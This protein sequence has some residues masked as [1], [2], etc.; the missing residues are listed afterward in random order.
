MSVVA[1]PSALFCVMCSDVSVLTR[2]IGDESD[3]LLYIPAYLSE[4]QKAILPGDG[5]PLD[6]SSHRHTP[7]TPLQA[8]SYAYKVHKSVAA[9]PRIAATWLNQ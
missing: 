7:L 5:T 4:N 3:L 2:S 9:V 8:G 1:H 6:M